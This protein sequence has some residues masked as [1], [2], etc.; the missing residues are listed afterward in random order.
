VVNKLRKYFR[1]GSGIEQIQKVQLE[2]D[3]LR[4]DVDSAGKRAKQE[5]LFYHLFQRD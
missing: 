1:L 4:N 2:T 5:M 3:R